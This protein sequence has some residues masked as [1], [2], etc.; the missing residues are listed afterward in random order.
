MTAGRYRPPPEQALHDSLAEV[1]AAL[2]RGDITVLVRKAPLNVQRARDQGRA[3]C[4]Q[5]LLGA[6]SGTYHSRSA[7]PGMVAVAAC[8]GRPVG[9][10]VQSAS[11]GLVDAALMRMALHPSELAWLES[12][13]DAA[14]RFY[15]LW[16]RKE[17][18]LK[19]LG[20]GLA[21]SPDRVNAGWAEGWQRID[22]CGQRV[23]VLELESDATHSLAVATLAAT[24]P[25]GVWMLP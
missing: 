21:I 8:R 24:P 4:T 22:L 7:T 12:R 14:Q 18:A 25:V 9:V 5:L 2:A 3:L 20:A 6:G 17:A 23:Q 19:A 10:D 16:T 13:H 11:A 1:H 15:G